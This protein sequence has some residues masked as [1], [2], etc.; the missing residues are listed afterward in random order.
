MFV[1][2][3]FL[4][5]KLRL[6]SRFMCILDTLIFFFERL[7]FELIC[8]IYGRVNLSLI[9][10]KYKYTQTPVSRNVFHHNSHYCWTRGVTPTE[11]PS[12]GRVMITRGITSPSPARPC[13]QLTAPRRYSVKAWTCHLCCYWCL[14]RLRFVLWCKEDCKLL[15]LRWPTSLCA[16]GHILSLCVGDFYVRRVLSPVP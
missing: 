14:V 3:I 5:L 13:S 10:R 11:L 1:F 9:H 2:K 6:P 16:V 15:I 12:F 4:A 7:N 8:V